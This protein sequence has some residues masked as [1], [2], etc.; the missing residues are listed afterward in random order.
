SSNHDDHVDTLDGLRAY[1]P[2]PVQKRFGIMPSNFT[3]ARQGHR[4][5]SSGAIGPPPNGRYCSILL[6]TIR[7]AMREVFFFHVELIQ[8]DTFRGRHNFSAPNGSMVA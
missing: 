1:H 3:G 8:C 7:R 2:K 5:H 6:A 4:C